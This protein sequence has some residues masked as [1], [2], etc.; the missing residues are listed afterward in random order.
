MASR[1]PSAVR[2]A[3]G[4]TRSDGS[5]TQAGLES[6]SPCGSP[7]PGGS[8]RRMEALGGGAVPRVGMED[9]ERVRVEG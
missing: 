5:V 6:P 1:H 7:G 2:L 9:G 4:V 3:C 8:F